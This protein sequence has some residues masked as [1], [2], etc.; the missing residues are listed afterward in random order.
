MALLEPRFWK[1]SEN[2]SSLNTPTKNQENSKLPRI[3]NISPGVIGIS[4]CKVLGK[5][6][7]HIYAKPTARNEKRDKIGLKTRK[8]NDFPDFSVL[9]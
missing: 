1:K 8:K 3:S 2:V 9:P 5:Y 4:T 7:R 6:W